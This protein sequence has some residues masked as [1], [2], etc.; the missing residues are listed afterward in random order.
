MKGNPIVLLT[1]ARRGRPEIAISE[2]WR[3]LHVGVDRFVLRMSPG[4][5]VAVRLYAT[6]YGQALPDTRILAFLDPGRLQ[7]RPG[8]LPVATPKSAVDF[9]ARVISDARGE[10]R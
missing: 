2:P 9:A 7:Q 8:A 10:L 5:C 1:Q 6:C 4:D 3:G